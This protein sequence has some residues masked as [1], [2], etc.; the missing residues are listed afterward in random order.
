[1][2]QATTIPQ[3]CTATIVWAQVHLAFASRL[4][5]AVQSTLEV[6]KT[7]LGGNLCQTGAGL[8]GRV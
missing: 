4:T 3:L 5:S 2:K 1:M 8:P 6:F 7:I